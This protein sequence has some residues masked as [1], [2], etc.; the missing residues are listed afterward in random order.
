RLPAQVAAAVAALLV[1]WLYC[2]LAGWGVPA[3]RTFF[4]LAVISLT[5]ILRIYVSPFR[6]LTIVA[7]VVVLLDPWALLASGFWLSF[8]AVYVLMTSSGWHGQAVGQSR[9]KRWRRALG[10]LTTATRLQLAITVGLMPLL[11][12][13]FHEVSLASPL[14]NAYAIPVVSLL[15]TPLALLLAAIALAPGLSAVASA[16]AWLGHA[17]LD[18]MMTPTVWLSGLKAASFNAAAAPLWLTALAWSG[19]VLATLPYGFPGRRLAW[20]LVTP[21]LCWWPGR[22]PKGG[23]DMHA[24]DVGQGSA[25]VIRTAHHAVLFDTGLR[26]SASSDAGMRI[27]WPFLRSQGIARLG[28]LIVSHADID[29]AGG[30]RSILE[31][32]PVDQSYSPF[33]LRAYLKREARLLGMSG[34]LPPLPPVMS[35][36]EYGMAWHV[37]GVSFEFLWPLQEQGAAGAASVLP[38]KARNEHAC[39]LRIR[40]RHHSALLSAD[41]GSRQEAVLVNRGLGAVDV[42]LAP[43]HG[44]KSSSSAAFVA[45]TQ[46]GH[47]VAQAGAWNRYGH[48][49]PGVQARWRDGGAHFWRTDQHGAISLY[50][51]PEGLRVRSER[52]N[53]RRYWQ[54]H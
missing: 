1:A 2:L 39:V 16:C 49:A 10:F 24:L 33:D 15:V 17:V 29:H 6:L 25:V 27:I 31:S 41:I 9:R 23:W 21:A 48:P 3:R 44:S 38:S 26:S 22:P 32:L 35:S 28:A 4:M 53:S 18:I 34:Q 54:H 30:V 42:V 52:V 11:A 20:L 40:G 37:D 8:G 46:A 43:H 14:A 51:R 47:V 7:F 5:Y 50:S 45:E 36:C 19:L 12:V 13:V